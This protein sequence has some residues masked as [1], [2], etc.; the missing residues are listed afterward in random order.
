MAG[1]REKPEDIVTKLRHIAK[2]ITLLGDTVGFLIQFRFGRTKSIIRCRVAYCR[3]TANGSNVRPA[4][5]HPPKI[6]QD[7]RMAGLVKLHCG[8]RPGTERQVMGCAG[9]FPHRWVILHWDHP[10]QRRSSHVCEEDRKH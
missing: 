10:R 6:L 5:L 3:C 2:Q 1:K 4:D 8:D 9:C 7:G